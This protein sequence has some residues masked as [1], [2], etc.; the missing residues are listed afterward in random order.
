MVDAEHEDSHR[1]AA[2]HR[3]RDRHAWNDPAAGGRMA[4]AH[5]ARPRC[6]SH[7]TR[8]GRAPPRP[9]TVVGPVAARHH[10]RRVCV[11]QEAGRAPAIR[12]CGRRPR[13]WP[14]RS[15]PG[16]GTSP[17]T[18]C[19]VT[20]TWIACSGCRRAPTREDRAPTIFGPCIPTTGRG[21]R[22]RSARRSR[23]A[24]RTGTRRSIACSSRGANAGCMHGGS[25][26]ATRMV[27]RSG[28]R[29]WSSTSPGRRSVTWS[30]GGFSRRPSVRSACSGRRCR[31]SPTSPTSSTCAAGFCTP[32]R[33]FSISGASRSRRPSA[34][35]SSISSTPNPSRHDCSARSSR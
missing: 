26:S 12:G 30:T 14:A 6:G 9:E 23:A 28:C 10:G 21:C 11:A 13:R 19:G 5:P 24:A 35:T 8:S 25:S 32:T 31:P 7:T 34:R 29:E 22:R 20:P 3:Q 4:L 18:A 1:T 27:R 16:R 15:A 17:A 2:L 33:R